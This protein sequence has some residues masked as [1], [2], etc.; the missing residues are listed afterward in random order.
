ML[1]LPIRIF[2]TDLFL[3]RAPS[4]NAIEER[5][6]IVYES[7]LL[8]LFKVCLKCQKAYL[9]QKHQPKSFGSNVKIVSTCANQDCKQEREWHAQPK[10]GNHHAGNV[11]ISAAILC[12]GGSQTKV[13]RVL[14]FMN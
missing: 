6:Y 13:L 1:S 10:M 12:T 11:C 3:C 14:N 2:C 7:N 5:K 4:E 9:V 8:E